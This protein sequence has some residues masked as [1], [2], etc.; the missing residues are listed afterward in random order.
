MPGLL[1][2]GRD[3]TERALFFVRQLQALDVTPLVFI[4]E[5]MLVMNSAVSAMH[6]LRDSGAIVGIHCCGNTDW[7][8]VLE[9]DFDVVSID[10]RLSL[11]ALVEDRDAWRTWLESDA[12]LSLGIIPTNAGARY[13][14]RELCESVEATLRATSPFPEILQRVMLTPAC[15][16]GLHSIADAERIMNELAQAQSLLRGLHPVV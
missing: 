15:G 6:S 5:P 11:E 12:W 9:L 16:L 1:S 10:A 13:D 7:P 3:P 4:D 14:V 2:S 8:R